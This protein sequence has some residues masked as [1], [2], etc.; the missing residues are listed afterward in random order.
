MRIPLFGWFSRDENHK[1]A[2]S[3]DLVAFSFYGRPIWVATAI[4]VRVADPVSP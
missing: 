1:K 4:P 3:A 2:T